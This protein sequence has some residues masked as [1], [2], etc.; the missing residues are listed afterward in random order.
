MPDR[1]ELKAH[2]E[3]SRFIVIATGPGDSVVEVGQQFAWIG[4][5]LRSSTYT[6]GIATCAPFISSTSLETTENHDTEPIP[7]LTCVVEFDLQ[8]PAVDATKDPGQCWH[9]MF[10]NPVMVIGFPIPFKTNDYALG[11]EMPL[12]IV[13]TLA[14]SSRVHE[15]HGKVFIKGFSTMVIATKKIGD[16]VVW[17]YFYNTDRGKLSHLDHTLG[18]DLNGS[19]SLSQLESSRHVVG[20]CSDCKVYAGESSVL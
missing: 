3:D 6:T 9:N 15:F 4:A 18:D 8:Q 1:T 20:W 2:L 12:N 10:R 7:R 13:T 19:I 5:A 11:L 16:L 17:H 14:G